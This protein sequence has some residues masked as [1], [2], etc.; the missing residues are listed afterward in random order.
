M[1]GRERRN[2]IVIAVKDQVLKTWLNASYY[3]PSIP[4]RRFIHKSYYLLLLVTTIGLGLR[5]SLF[6]LHIKAATRALRNNNHYQLIDGE[7]KVFEN[8]NEP[9]TVCKR[10]IIAS[11][12]YDGRLFV[13]R[14]DVALIVWMMM[15]LMDQISGSSSSSYSSSSV[16]KAEVLLLLEIMLLLTAVSVL[17]LVVVVIVA[18]AAAAEA[19]RLRVLFGVMPLVRRESGHHPHGQRDENVGQQQE[20]PNLHRQRIHERK[21]TRRRRLRYLISLLLPFIYTSCK[22]LSYWDHSTV[23]INCNYW[24]FQLK[25][26]LK[27]LVKKRKCLVKGWQL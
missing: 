2:R 18:T 3:A 21:E 7:R 27:T 20:Q 14:E 26:K 24:C 12:Q 10:E 17:V 11:S 16:A 25:L 9:E 6:V 4:S 23:V 19:P 13:S 8:E 22:V 1:V 5:Q 15:M